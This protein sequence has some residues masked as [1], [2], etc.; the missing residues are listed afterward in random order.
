MLEK[1]DDPSLHVKEGDK[2]LP[3]FEDKYDSYEIK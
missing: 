1:E 3:E 2:E